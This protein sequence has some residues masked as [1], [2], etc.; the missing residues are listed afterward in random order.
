M[1]KIQIKMWGYVPPTGALMVASAI[2]CN[3]SSVS[4]GW[5]DRS[6]LGSST[7]GFMYVEEAAY[8]GKSYVRR[9][10]G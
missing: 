6:E 2:N 9:D 10:G 1:A 5:S 3:D 7:S 8:D 4:G